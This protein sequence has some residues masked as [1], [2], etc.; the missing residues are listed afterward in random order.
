MSGYDH[1][2]EAR[3][4]YNT[5]RYKEAFKQVRLA[6]R[7]IFNQ[8]SSPIMSKAYNVFMSYAKASEPF[9]CPEWTPETVMVVRLLH[10]ELDASVF[11]IWRSGYANLSRDEKRRLVESCLWFIRLPQNG[12]LDLYDAIMKDYRTSGTYEQRWSDAVVSYHT[13]ESD[14]APLASVLLFIEDNGERH[15]CETVRDVEW[16][17]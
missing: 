3:K 17:L 16:D 2:C 6:V 11:L 1:T 10:R 4:G 9:Q 5:E 12:I 8:P 15:F 14:V 7:Y 13:R